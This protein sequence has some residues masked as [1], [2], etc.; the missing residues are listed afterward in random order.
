[1]GIDIRNVRQVIHIGPPPTVQEYFQETGRAGRD[2]ESS[3]AILYYNNRH[4]TRNKP[5][6]QEEIKMYCWSKGVCLRRLLLQYLDVKQPV[7]V[8]PGHICCS[9]C[10][11]ICVC[12]ECTFNF[13]CTDL[14]ALQ[15]LAIFTS[16][17]LLKTKFSV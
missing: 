3:K 8:S 14:S 5:G 10:K 4:I 12:I 6:I 16:N 2:G 7:P 1:M 17:Y 9:V 11:D 13:S 15:L